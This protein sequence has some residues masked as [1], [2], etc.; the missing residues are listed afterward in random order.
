MEEYK[1]WDLTVPGI[2]F[3]ARSG[4]IT[5]FK[6]TIEAS[7]HPKYFHFRFSPED[8]MFAVESCD[9]GDGGSYRLPEKLN[10]KH[11]DFKCIDLVR[12]IFRTCKWDKRRTYRIGGTVYQPT[13]DMVYFDLDT[14]LVVIE[15]RVVPVLL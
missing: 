3:S 8:R 5:I 11:Y 1:N 2:S 15:G 4:R 13:R 7:G 6:T 10:R 14:A 9:Y 12:F